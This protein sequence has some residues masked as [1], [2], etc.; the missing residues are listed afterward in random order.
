MSQET[1]SRILDPFFTTKFTGRGLG[2]AE[3]AGIVKSHHGAIIVDSE[4][5]KGT[6]I[7]A[8]FPVS[9][10]T[11]TP[12]VE[13]RE[14]VPTVKTPSTSFTRRKTILVVDDEELVRSLVQRRLEALGYDTIAASDGD[15]GVQ[16]F[17]DR[18]DEI[19]LVLLDFAMPRMN[20]VEAFRELILI[21]PDVKIIISSGYTENVVMQSFPDQPP[22]AV[23]HKPYKM[24]EL[25]AEL[26]RL[27]G[28]CNRKTSLS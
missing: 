1:L 11:T 14:T 25:K 7:T 26:E 2:M 20:G 27:L 8:L 19:D 21:K 10:K 3:V 23:L 13:A 16:V 28:A 15:E 6:K 4:P 17:R 18:A 5:G 22:S 12:F 9:A 24:E